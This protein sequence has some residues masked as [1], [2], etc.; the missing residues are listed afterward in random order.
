[1]VMRHSSSKNAWYIFR[2]A[3]NNYVPLFTVSRGFM[4]ADAHSENP[5]R[6][7]QKK[8]VFGNSTRDFSMGVN[9]LTPPR[10]GRS[11]KKT[12]ELPHVFKS[13]RT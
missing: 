8:R 11:M 3:K 9:E 13:A 7:N 5:V 6:R 1:M 10:S 4:H 12:L 2:I